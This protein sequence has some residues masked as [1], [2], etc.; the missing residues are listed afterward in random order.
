AEFGLPDE[1]DGD[2]EEPIVDAAPADVIEAPPLAIELPEPDIDLPPEDDAHRDTIEALDALGGDGF[3]VS[4]DDEELPPLNTAPPTSDSGDDNLIDDEIIEIFVEEAGEVLDALNTY[5]PRWAMNQHDQE[6]LVEFRRAFHTLKGSGR[7]VG[8]GTV[9]ELAWSIENMMNRVIDNSIVATP[10]LIELVRTVHGLIPELV[11]AFANGQDDPYD[12]T[13]LRD[14]ADALAR[15]DS[16]SVVPSVGGA[17]PVAESSVA[18]S[19]DDDAV[20]ELTLTLPEELAATAPMESEPDIEDIAFDVP[21]PDAGADEDTS[22]HLDVD[23]VEEISFEATAFDSGAATDATDPVLLDIFRNEGEANLAL[24]RDWLHQ[25]DDDIS[26][27]LLDDSVH[28]ALHTLKGSARMAEIEAVAGVA[29]PAEKF[30]KDMI[31]NN[32]LANRDVIALLEDVVAV[33]SGGFQAPHPMMP[34]LA[35]TE[36]LLARIAMAHEALSHVA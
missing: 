36:P 21:E 9:G 31:N 34:P 29:E 20:E 27:H 24:I 30:V 15:G 6:A 4:E 33:I 32:A 13:P 22:W 14:A 8:A 18:A 16:L 3:E 19:D 28:R 17:Q 25:L 11:N 23:D 7:M 1:G 26:E 35:G 12:V 5:F 10:T 2:E